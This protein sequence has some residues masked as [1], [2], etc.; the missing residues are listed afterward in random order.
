MSDTN[1]T[2]LIPPNHSPAFWNLL[3]GVCPKT[4]RA[5]A[6]LDGVSWLG[7]DWEKLPTLEQTLLTGV[8]ERDGEK[9]ESPVR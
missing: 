1:P 3:R 9:T 8:G 2:P 6:F 4:D 7:H 5:N